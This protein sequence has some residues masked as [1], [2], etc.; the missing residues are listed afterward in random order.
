MIYI[1][2]IS[3]NKNIEL[4]KE[5]NNLEVQAI[6]I[7]SEKDIENKKIDILV[8]EDCLIDK[9][10]INNILNNIKYLIIQDNI[11]DLQLELDREI[12][13]ITFGFNHKSTV[14]ISSRTEDNIVICIQRTINRINNKEI[15]P[16]E[17]K[18]ENLN[19]YNINKYIIKKIIEEI[20]EK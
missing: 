7:K 8:I 19:K 9:K 4:V 6:N 2:F 14:T 1:G 11:N 15:Q 5:L 13:V 16:Q 20:L 10:V 12:N 3:K 18:I 17:I